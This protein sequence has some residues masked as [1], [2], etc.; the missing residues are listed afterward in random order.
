ML[1]TSL[2]FSFYQRYMELKTRIKETAGTIL[3]DTRDTNSKF[4]T[5]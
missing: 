5:R 4:S 3:S 1:N 2:N